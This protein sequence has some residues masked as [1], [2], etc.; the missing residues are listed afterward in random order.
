MCRWKENS[1]GRYEG[2]ETERDR[3]RANSTPMWKLLYLHAL[4]VNYRS[5]SK[6]YAAFTITANIYPMVTWKGRYPNTKHV[7][8]GKTE[9]RKKRKG[10]NYFFI[11]KQY[12]TFNPTTTTY[13]TLQV[14]PREKTAKSWPSSV[15][16]DITW[17][18]MLDKH[19]KKAL[20]IIIISYLY[21]FF[22][23]IYVVICQFY[24]K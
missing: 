7:Q 6:R 22:F 2:G 14:S 11:F 23:F 15:H 24:A 5:M 21:S 8:D 18:F 19:V 13:K 20:N 10:K 16:A 4:Y 1:K 3:K 9:R 17:R 12:S